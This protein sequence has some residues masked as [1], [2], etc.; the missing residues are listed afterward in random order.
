[1]IRKTENEANGNVPM[2]GYEY[3]AIATSQAHAVETTNY[4][5]KN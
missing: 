5:N 2:H 1:M 4:S 3:W